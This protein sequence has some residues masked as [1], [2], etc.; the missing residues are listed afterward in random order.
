VLVGNHAWPKLSGLA[1]YIYSHYIIFI[2][3]Y[4][5]LSRPMGH[6]ENLGEYLDLC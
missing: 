5:Y 2:C 1:F 4:L 6:W 3:I